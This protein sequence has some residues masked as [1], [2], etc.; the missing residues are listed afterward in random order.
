MVSS[1]KWSLSTV[2]KTL[3]RILSLSK[4]TGLAKCLRALKKV[5]AT[6]GKKVRRLIG[7]NKRLKNE[8][9]AA[10]GRITEMTEAEKTA[11]AEIESIITEAEG[12]IA[13]LD[14]QP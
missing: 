9:V 14:A 6:L 8:L 12:L 2:L 4:K 10:E 11:A 5:L 7:E 3:K 1:K 13:E